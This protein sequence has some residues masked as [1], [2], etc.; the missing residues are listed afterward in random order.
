MAETINASDLK[1]VDDGTIY[2][3]DLKRV[4]DAADYILP[5]GVSRLL[6]GSPAGFGSGLD[7]TNIWGDINRP[8][9]GVRQALLNAGSGQ[10]PIAGFQQGYINPSQT[11]SLQDT[12]LKNASPQTTSALTN[13]I[14]GL[15]AST[16][17]VG[18]D[19]VAGM[20]NPLNA[21]ASLV[22]PGIAKS[23]VGQFSPDQ[24]I[25]SKGRTALDHVFGLDVNTKYVP[26][27][28]QAYR[29]T[30]SQF[31]DSI[32]ELATGKLGISDDI[33][34]HIAD[35]TP[36][37][38]ERSANAMNNT[39]D[40]PYQMLVNGLAQKDQAVGDAY[41]KA[42]SQLPQG[43][44][45]SLPKTFKATNNFLENNNIIDRVGNLTDYGKQALG[46]DPSLNKVYGNY[47]L[48]RT[49]N[50]AGTTVGQRANIAPVNQSQWTVLRNN[51]SKARNSANYQ[52]PIT[53]LLDALHTDASDAG[54]GLQD[55]RDAARTNFQMDELAKK[56]VTDSG[57]NKLKNIFKL[58]T[59]QAQSLEALD[60]YLG[61]NVV[62]RSKDLTAN[63]ALQKI[64][65][66]G[67]SQIEKPSFINAQVNKL[68]EANPA[69]MGDV[70]EAENR[71]R[72]LIGTKSS[73]LNDLLSQMKFRRKAIG[74]GG[75]IG[76]LTGADQI[77]S[78]LK[79]KILPSN[80]GAE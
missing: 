32:K 57:E 1:P 28:E 60:N 27:A 48:M 45:L 33:V 46:D 39:H 76:A 30:V 5:E 11:P 62:Q 25:V 6:H 56:F 79:R 70:W 7:S 75:A 64:Y 49:T 21:L 42:W 55:A 80:T 73:T 71:L 3:S 13:F 66:V 52:S 36:T 35:R 61:T 18:A 47:L 22:A 53:G 14:G 72:D 44:F 51:F 43:T 8:A 9:Q 24:F 40:T 50:G 67:T 78:F 15:P 63:E 20:A 54:I 34:Q 10:N 38:I 4:P 2:A 31:P 17:G 37:S 26:Q 65:G 23:P 12:F 19:I 59:Q 74:V 69:K 58:P 68:A 41:N 16:A 77:G 29:Q